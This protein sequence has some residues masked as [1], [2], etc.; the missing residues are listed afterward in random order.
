[1]AWHG[2]RQGKNS[3]TLRVINNTS[4]L[5]IIR[6]FN[7]AKVAVNKVVLKLHDACRR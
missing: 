7:F 5:I 6:A 4:S 1:M 3:S 2:R